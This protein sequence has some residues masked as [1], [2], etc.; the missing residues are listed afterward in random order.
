[1]PAASAAA[2]AAAPVA[3]PSAA[4]STDAAFAPSQVA[5]MATDGSSGSKGNDQSSNGGAEA[6]ASATAPS[7]TSEANFAP[8]RQSADTTAQP[9]PAQA[10]PAG[11]SLIVVGSILLI[12]AGAVLGLLRLAAR[13]L[14]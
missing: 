1:M 5:A 7:S 2:S 8:P 11:P 12:V 3:A 13:R 6:D 9:V 4:P 10:Q 14:V